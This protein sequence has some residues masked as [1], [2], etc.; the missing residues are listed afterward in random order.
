MGLISECA[1]RF[2]GG[3]MMFDLPP[4][5]AAALTRR[6]TRASRRY[7]IPP[8]PFSLSRSAAD[9]LVNTVPGVR[10]VHHVQ[11]SSG[12]GVVINTL[13]QT[14]QRFSRLRPLL[15]VWIVLEFG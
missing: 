12:R 8:M 4:A 5:W 2:P 14:A 10:A 13:V 7:R 6:G 3:Q 11:I 15:P 9:D 1:K